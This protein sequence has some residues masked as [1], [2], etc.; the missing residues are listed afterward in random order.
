MDVE[1]RMP[2]EPPRQLRGGHTRVSQENYLGSSVPYTEPGVAWSAGGSRGRECGECCRPETREDRD[3]WP[4]GPKG[5][6]GPSGLFNSYYSYQLL[7]QMFK[8]EH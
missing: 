8:I 7:V 2:C 6:R 3:R 1:F 4:K 5:Q